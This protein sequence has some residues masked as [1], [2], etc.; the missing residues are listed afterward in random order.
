MRDSIESNRTIR[1]KINKDMIPIEIEWFNTKNTQI[2]DFVYS[3]NSIEYE[4]SNRIEKDHEIIWKR[5]T[6][7]KDIESYSKE[8]T[9]NVKINNIKFDY[10]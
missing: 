2:N 1:K 10:K 5:E 8:H 3:Y 4:Q 7:W 6:T 9:R